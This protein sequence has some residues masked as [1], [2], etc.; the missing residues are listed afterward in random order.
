[1][2]HIPRCEHW[3]LFVRYEDGT[4]KLYDADK[5]G[6]TNIQTKYKEKDWSPTKSNKVDR[7]VLVGNTSSTFNQD[8][9]TKAC[10]DVTRDRV[11]SIW[12]NNC[13]EWVKDVLSSLIVDNYLVEGAFEE[14]KF[15]NEITPWRGW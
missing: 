1:M 13:Q 7:I 11:F 4:G 3:G 2:I 9:M 14:L 12:S 10:E 6:W 15:N 8:T 5:A